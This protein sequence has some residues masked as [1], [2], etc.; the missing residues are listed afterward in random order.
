[1]NELSDKEK[2]LRALVNWAVYSAN[3]VGE[4]YGEEGVKEYYQYLM[5]KIGAKIFELDGPQILRALQKLDIILGSET[6]YEE[7]DEKVVLT[8][9]C[10]TGGR[11][12]REGKSMRGP[13]GTPY[14]CMHCKI[15]LEDM[16]RERGIPMTVRYADKGEGCKFIFEKKELL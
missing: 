9:R 8:V 14:Y 12:E 3:W 5:E 11:A 7:D 13:S 16:A 2:A 1:V 6:V 15:H 4:K 10:N